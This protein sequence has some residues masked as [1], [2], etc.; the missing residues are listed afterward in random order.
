MDVNF[1]VLDACSG[2]GLVADSRFFMLTISGI[3]KAYGPKELLS[4]ASLQVNK[5]DRIGL[6][7]PNGAGKSTL[8]KM[9]LN[10]VEPDSGTIQ[11]Q[12]GSVLGYLPQEMADVADES[13]L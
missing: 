7:G 5:G 11:F 8:L 6:V 9:V 3:S 4:D 1:P 10:R 13:V 2:W 12:R